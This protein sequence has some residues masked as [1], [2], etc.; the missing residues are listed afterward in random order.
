MCTAQHATVNGK[1]V[2]IQANTTVADVRRQFNDEVGGDQFVEGTKALRD[3]DP[4]RH[5]AKLNTIPKIVKG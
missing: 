3:S 1:R 5:G 4:V 2:S